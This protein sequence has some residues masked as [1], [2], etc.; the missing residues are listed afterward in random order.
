MK[1]SSFQETN[2][3]HEDIPQEAECVTPTM[4]L[5]QLHRESLDEIDMDLMYVTR[6]VTVITPGHF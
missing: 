2:F 6:Q 5:P 4:T 3:A 1:K